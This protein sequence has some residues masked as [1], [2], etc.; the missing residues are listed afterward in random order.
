MSISDSNERSDTQQGHSV[1]EDSQEDDDQEQDLHAF[2]VTC[3]GEL[4]SASML[5]RD[6]EF[7]Q[8]SQKVGMCFSV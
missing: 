6:G 7:I 5:A 8:R 1:G 2:D 4:V 3:T